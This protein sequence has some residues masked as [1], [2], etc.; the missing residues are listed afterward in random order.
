MPRNYFD[1]RIRYGDGWGQSPH[2]NTYGDGDHYFM[3]DPR[4]V[5]VRRDEAFGADGMGQPWAYEEE[6]E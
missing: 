2:G 3:L 6:V 5:F 1:G 4:G